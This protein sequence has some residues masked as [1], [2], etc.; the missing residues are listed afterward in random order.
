VLV[1]QYNL[2]NGANILGITALAHVA[3]N[4][5]C[6]SN[7]IVLQWTGSEGRPPVAA[8]SFLPKLD[9]LPA[10]VASLVYFVNGLGEAAQPTMV[11]SLFREFPHP[12]VCSNGIRSGLA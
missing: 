6:C 12:A 2:T 5:A 10:D 3:R 9:E 11:A 4:P 1:T 8:P 7:S